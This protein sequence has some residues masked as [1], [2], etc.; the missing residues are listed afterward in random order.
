VPLPSGTSALGAYAMPEREKNG[1]NESPAAHHHL[2]PSRTP[3]SLLTNK[4]RT[5]L[6]FCPT[7]FCRP[8]TNAWRF[9]V[10]ST[11]DPVTN[12]WLVEVSAEFVVVG[13]Q[14][15]GDLGGKPRMNAAE[16]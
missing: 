12:W 10:G 9:V 2:N 5:K 3:R 8:T 16:H 13:F 7:C 1:V 6:F 14:E 4:C 11:L 15:V